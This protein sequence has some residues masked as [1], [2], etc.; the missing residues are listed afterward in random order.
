[1]LR[2]LRNAILLKQTRLSHLL[3]HL[4]M[5]LDPAVAPVIGR[6]PCRWV[7]VEC[8]ERDVGKREVGGE[9]ETFGELVG[10]GAVA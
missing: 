7:Q 10:V 1:M 8:A 9:V 6:A 2:L 4:R 3:A 5:R